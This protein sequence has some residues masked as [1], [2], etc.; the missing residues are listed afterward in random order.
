MTASFVVLSNYLFN[1][2]SKFCV[3]PKSLKR[4]ANTADKNNDKK[5]SAAEEKDAIDVLRRAKKQKE[6]DVQGNFT[7][8]MDAYKL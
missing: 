3:I 7:S 8:F 5:I 1:E 6:N 2:K 4:I